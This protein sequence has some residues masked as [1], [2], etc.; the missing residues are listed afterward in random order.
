MELKLSKSRKKSPLE[1]ECENQRKA[2]A[3]NYKKID[4]LN[5]KL[6]RL[7]LK[8][9]K[10]EEKRSFEDCQRKFRSHSRRF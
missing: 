8:D 7:A 2:L 10:N 5:K 4:D 6:V 3:S 9:Q 1:L